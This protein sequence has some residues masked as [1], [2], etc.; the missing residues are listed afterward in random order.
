[1]NHYYL[2]VK[3][4]EKFTVFLVVI[5]RY[6]HWKCKRKITNL[7]VN[8]VLLKL[9]VTKFLLW[10][11]YLQRVPSETSPTSAEDKLE[12]ECPRCEEPVLSTTK[13]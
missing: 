2:L 7:D 6:R 1:M 9:Y 10:I 13:T 4:C 11:L 8:T 5:H 12:D 3:S